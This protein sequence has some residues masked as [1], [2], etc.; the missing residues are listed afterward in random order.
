[1]EAGATVAAFTSAD[2]IKLFAATYLPLC[3]RL[4]TA[5]VLDRAALA[6]AMGL[7]VAPG[8][9]TASAAMVEALQI[10]LRRPRPGQARQPGPRREPP[11]RVIA[12][13]LD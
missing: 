3:E 1:M 11:L 2:L 6:D 10:V 12:G 7:Y 5:G 8:E 13:G 4:E 9:T